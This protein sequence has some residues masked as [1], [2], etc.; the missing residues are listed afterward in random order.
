MHES[1]G[2]RSLEAQIPVKALVILTFALHGTTL[3]KV[4]Q[5]VPHK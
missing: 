5:E 1:S 2:R 4:D 3:A